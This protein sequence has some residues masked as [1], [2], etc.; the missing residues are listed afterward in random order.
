ML[1]FLRQLGSYE[2]DGVRTRTRPTA[3]SVEPQFCRLALAAVSWS[4]RSQYPILHPAP[5]HRPNEPPYRE[6]AV[7]VAGPRFSVVIPT[8]DRP[9]EV[10]HCVNSVRHQRAMAGDVELIVVDDSERG[11][12]PMSLGA[13]RIVRTSGSAGPTVARNMGAAVA[14]GEWI[15]FLDDDDTPAAGWLDAFRRLTEP[16]NVGVASVGYRYDDGK[17]QVVTPVPLGPAYGGLAA[18]L[19]AGTFAVRTEVFR[20]VGGFEESIRSA[21]FTEL[22]LRLLPAVRRGG[23]V[24]A[25]TEEELISLHARPRSQRHG[26][27]PAVHWEAARF[28]VEHHGAALASDPVAYRG[29]LRAAVN[30]AVR[31][32]AWSEARRYAWVAARGRRRGIKDL[33][34][35]VLVWNRWAARR[36]WRTEHSPDS[37]SFAPT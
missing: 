11:S 18:S 3:P 27:R 31:V 7:T 35:L 22:C 26:Y 36:W 37:T 33:V 21:E 8:R 16:P 1:P 29:Q 30:A 25:V 13:D 24:A 9:I 10:E 6:A 12:T 17:A 5:E 2:A 32:E 14:R 4:D 19:L 28:I 20:A 34:R 23:F 15:I